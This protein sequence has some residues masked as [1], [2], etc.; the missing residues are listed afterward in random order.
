MGSGKY[1]SGRV[2]HRPSSMPIV[3]TILTFLLPPKTYAVVRSPK[4]RFNATSYRHSRRRRKDGYDGHGYGAGS[5][6]C[7]QR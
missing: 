7:L 6:Q 1:T 4:V 3:L 5:T 2:H